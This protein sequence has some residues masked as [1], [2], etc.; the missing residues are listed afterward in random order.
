MGLKSSS[1]MEQPQAAYQEEWSPDRARQLYEGR[2]IEVY[3]TKNTPFDGEYCVAWCLLCSKS[4]L[5]SLLR[6]THQL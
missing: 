3:G 1:S 4:N 6:R 2:E 5:V